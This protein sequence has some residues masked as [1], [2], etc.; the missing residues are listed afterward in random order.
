MI[1]QQLSSS[2]RKSRSTVSSP[3]WLVSPTTCPWPCVWLFPPVK[4]SLRLTTWKKKYIYCHWGKTHGQERQKRLA[5]YRYRAPWDSAVVWED[6]KHSETDGWSTGG[7]LGGWMN[8]NKRVTVEEW[9]G[10]CRGKIS[11]EIQFRKPER[12]SSSC[13]SHTHAHTNTHHQ[14]TFWTIEYRLAP[15]L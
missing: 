10:P 14:S 9:Y 3:S 1:W 4:R 15:L 6:W 7:A 11:R 13:V 2:C 5:D 12:Y 8:T